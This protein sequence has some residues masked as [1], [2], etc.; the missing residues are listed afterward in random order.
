[1]AVNGKAVSGVVPG[2]YLAIRRRWA[3]GDGIRLSLDMAPQMLEANA[4]VV[5]D[6]G[7]VAVQ[8]G[9]LVYCLEQLD[10]AQGVALADVAVTRGGK[11]EKSFTETF[12]KDL[13]G[14]V[15]VLRHEGAAQAASVERQKLYFSASVPAGKSS[16]IDLTFIPYYAWANRVPTPMEVWTP[17]V[18]S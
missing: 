13:L 18:K 10:Q 3:A 7:R 16:K 12:E 8:R 1:V 17:I 2:R 6:D 9:P 14:G 4:R 15:M 5:E 11:G